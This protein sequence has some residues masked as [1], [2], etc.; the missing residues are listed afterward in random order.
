MA[1]TMTYDP[2]TDTVTTEGN[3]TPDEQDSLQVGE[4]LVNEQEQLLA[5]KY[6]NAEELEKAYVELQKKFGEKGD[7]DSETTGNS[8]SSD[9][10][11]NTKK[12]ETTDETADYYL[13]DG[14]VNYESV[15]ETYGEQ[16]GNIFKNSDV[17]P[18]SI[19]KHFH[20]NNGVITDDM[21]QSLENAGLSR[22]SI[23]A[24][25]TGRAI[26][27]GYTEASSIDVSDADI[28]SIKNSVGGESE[29][30]NIVSWAGQ[31]LDQKSIDAFD[32]IVES[33]NTDAIKLAISGLKSQY[34][35]ANGYEGRMLS[36]KAP[37]TSGDVFRSQAQVVE[38]M[39]D[40]RYDNDPAYRQDLIEKLDR[41][42]IDF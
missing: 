18:W 16:L 24:Y 22:G 3:L 8:E 27:S 11:E 13:E 28:S 6:K 5:G 4:Q 37:K 9:S 14:S 39:S 36:G 30:N 15:N 25:L 23:D 29:Y 19:S 32:G 10:K 2:G 42:N 31:N 20:E 7:E 17:D 26:E 34:E 35:N 38:A 40:P 33:G 1:E 41:S 12:T 21:Y